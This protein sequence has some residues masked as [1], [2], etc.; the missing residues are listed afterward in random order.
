MGLIKEP[1]GVDFLI[2]SQPLS[3]KERIEISEFIKASK[4]KNKIVASKP[5]LRKNKKVTT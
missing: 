2:Q 1:N 5:T 4:D 3:E